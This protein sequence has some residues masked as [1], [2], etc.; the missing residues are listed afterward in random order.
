MQGLDGEEMRPCSA[1]AS[2]PKT[3]LRLEFPLKA[4]PVGSAGIVHFMVDG[5]EQSERRESA[6]TAFRSQHRS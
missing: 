2:A 5:T 1:T 3:N 6:D 4:L